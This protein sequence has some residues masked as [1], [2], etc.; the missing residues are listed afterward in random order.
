MSPRMPIVA[1]DHVQ[2][3]EG[4]D[5]DLPFNED[6]FIQE[7]QQ[8]EAMEEEEEGFLLF[9]NEIYWNGMRTGDCALDDRIEPSDFLMETYEN[10]VRDVNFIAC[11]QCAFPILPMGEIH[12]TIYSRRLPFIRIAHA[13]RFNRLNSIHVA[14]IERVHWQTH[15][16]CINCGALLSVNALNVYNCIIDE[17][18]FDE[19]CLILDDDA[20]MYMRMES[21]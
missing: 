20:L 5:S 15:F 13:I 16:Q 10:M 17:Y 21:Y 12:E 8:E 7:E 14:R 18:T 4:V 9:P 19:Q 2:P 11:N 6:D 1:C 3:V